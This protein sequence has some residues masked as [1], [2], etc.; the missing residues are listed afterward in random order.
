MSDKDS[1]SRIY[2]L[3]GIPEARIST[4]CC[5]CWSWLLG[6]RS[7]AF[8]LQVCPLAYR[9]TWM[10]NLMDLLLIKSKSGDV[11]SFINRKLQMRLKNKHL[12]YLN[13]VVKIV[14]HT[15]IQS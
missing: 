7:V 13:F 6:S 3:L 14:F 2:L 9:C 10:Y 5:L 8:S 12:L 11:G 1:C 4:L 15:L